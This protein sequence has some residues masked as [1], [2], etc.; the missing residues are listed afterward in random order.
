MAGVSPAG[1]HPQRL[2]IVGTEQPPNTEIDPSGPIR[3]TPVSLP[4]T[5]SFQRPT[6]ATGSLPA[7]TR[8]FPGSP[9][10][11]GDTG[12]TDATGW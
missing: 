8:R 4:P 5:C 11:S 7:T 2:P 6:S 1:S 9:L 12:R 10:P 3:S